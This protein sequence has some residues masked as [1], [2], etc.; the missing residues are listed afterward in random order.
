[1]PKH[2]T[3]RDVAAHAGVSVTTVS[4][5]VRNWPYISEALRHRVQDSINTLGYSPHIVAQGLRT[6]QTQAIAFIVPDLSNPY[7]AEIVAAAEDAAQARGYTLLVFNTH[8][9][10]EREAQCIQR[11]A[12]RWADGLLIAQSASAA[13]T[14][15]SWHDLHIP[16][17]AVDR[18]P[19]SGLHPACAVDN[20]LVGSTA[21][22]HLIRLGHQKIAHIAGPQAVRPALDRCLGYCNMLSQHH[23]SYNRIVYSSATWG[24]NDGHRCMTELLDSD[25]PPTAVFASNDRVA[26]GALHAI[27]E[28]G[29]R[30]PVDISLI[31]V[32][33]IEISAHLNPP[34]T[35]MRQ[36]LDQLANSA[37]EM[38]L[39][40]I[41]EEP[42]EPTLRLL[43]PEL[44]VRGSTA[45][46]PIPAKGD[47]S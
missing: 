45:P 6:G 25:D 19:E 31:G 23:L 39:H 44:I 12:L 40:V 11:A 13:A 38:L 42:L 37:V 34:L 24:P 21:T 35:T 36:P 1:M 4:N 46:P 3:L 26:I 28:R 47:H 32:D 18:I 43:K 41:H 2:I 8:E 16:I 27:S 14:R 7:F 15:T 20:L 17:I 9:D 29:L 22:E 5:V 30:V 10:P 33:D